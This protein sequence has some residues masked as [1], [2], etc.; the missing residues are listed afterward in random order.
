MADDVDGVRVARPRK[1]GISNGGGSGAASG[2]MSATM[3]RSRTR[4]RPSASQSQRKLINL[5]STRCCVMLLF[6]S[7]G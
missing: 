2:S 6:L 7:Y 3:D 5:T 1:T 4:S